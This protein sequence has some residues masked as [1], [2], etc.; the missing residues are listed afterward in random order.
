MSKILRKIINSNFIKFKQAVKKPDYSFHNKLKNGNNKKKI[1]YLYNFLAN[2]LWEYSKYETLI[3]NFLPVST[4]IKYTTQKEL[5]QATSAFVE[6][7]SYL[8]LD[9]LIIL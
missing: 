3:A 7:I 1:K 6:I 9:Y 2:F 5:R 8:F 4:K